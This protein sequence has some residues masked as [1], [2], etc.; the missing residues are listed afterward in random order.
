MERK[1]TSV[2]GAGSIRTWDDVYNFKSESEK[3]FM[4][5]CNLHYLDAYMAKTRTDV[6]ALTFLTSLKKGSRE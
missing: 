5:R 1:K 3:V 4:R 2:K 6:K